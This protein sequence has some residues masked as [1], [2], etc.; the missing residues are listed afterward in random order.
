MGINVRVVDRVVEPVV[1][2]FRTQTFFSV[3]SNQ[4]SMIIICIEGHILVVVAT[5]GT[6]RWRQKILS[7]RHLTILATKIGVL[8]IEFVCRVVIRGRIIAA[9]ICEVRVLPIDVAG[10]CVR[11]VR[12][13][14]LI[15]V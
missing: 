12:I 10:S 2:C 9:T 1:D 7:K 5:V 8:S 15:H 13:L 14:S 4:I 3:L 11:S 6:S